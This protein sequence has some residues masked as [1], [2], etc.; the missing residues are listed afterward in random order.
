MIENEFDQVRQAR[1]PPANPSRS[2]SWT[3]H[4]PPGSALGTFASGLRTLHRSRSALQ[5][6]VS[7]VTAFVAPYIVEVH[8]RADALASIQKSEIKNRKSNE[9]ITPSLP[10][11]ITPPIHINPSI[12]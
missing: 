4:W 10:R 8:R 2:T 6:P 11:S 9:P 7:S 3:V 1:R 5:S 12:P